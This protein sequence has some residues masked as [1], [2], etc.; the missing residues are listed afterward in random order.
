MAQPGTNCT[1]VS[2]PCA[3]HAGASSIE[4]NPWAKNAKNRLHWVSLS[5]VEH[6][7]HRLTPEPKQCK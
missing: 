7:Y 3:L 6:L 1:F 5:T 2:S 4:A